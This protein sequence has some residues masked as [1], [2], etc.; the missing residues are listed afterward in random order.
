M[1]GFLL[2]ENLPAR[3]RFTP[4]L[5]VLYARFANRFDSVAQHVGI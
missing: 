1:K 3:L 5:P 2:D 4:S